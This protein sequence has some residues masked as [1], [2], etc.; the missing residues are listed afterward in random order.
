LRSARRE[1]SDRYVL[2][3][4][5]VLAFLFGEEGAGEVKRIL[6]KAEEGEAAVFFHWNNLAEVYYIVRRESSRRRALEA[7][8]LVKAM[9]I[10]LIEFD[11]SL[12]LKAAELKAT[13]PISYADSFAAATACTMD[14]KLVTGDPEF[15]AL[16]DLIAIHWLPR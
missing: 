12:W 2:D 11:E 5:A 10:R 6:R 4:F 15:K 3:S 14:A 9:P 1:G 16:G 7:I 13:F 8:A